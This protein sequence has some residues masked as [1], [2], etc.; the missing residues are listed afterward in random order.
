MITRNN[1][2]ITVDDPKSSRAIKVEKNKAFNFNYIFAQYCK[3]NKLG[4]YR[5][6]KEIKDDDMESDEFDACV[7][8]LRNFAKKSSNQNFWFF[9]DEMKTAALLDEFGNVIG[10]VFN[11]PQN[12]KSIKLAGAFTIDGDPVNVTEY[13]ISHS[14]KN[15]EKA[16]YEQP[17]SKKG[18]VWTFHAVC[19]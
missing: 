4:I 17:V 16:R 19:P 15:I 8:L 11:A 10:E 3:N 13:K 1:I 12:T 6:N 2:K 14:K 5:K 7:K 18:E 9:I